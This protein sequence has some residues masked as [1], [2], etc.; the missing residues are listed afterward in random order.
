MNCKELKYILQ[1]KLLD[2]L[3]DTDRFLI[4]QHIQSCNSCNELFYDVTNTLGLIEEDKKK[5]AHPF[6][7]E[8]LLNKIQNES[9][10]IKSPRIF[11]TRK[12]LQTAA[13][14]ILFL[15]SVSAGIFLGRNYLIS[16]ENQHYTNNEQYTDVQ[17]TN[18]FEEYVRVEKYL[19]E[20]NQ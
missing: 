2:E 14:V 10:L 6:F 1:T 12:I 3:N 9:L 16:S 11:I 13:A 4:N 15:L 18:Y 7:K 17:Y 20:E 8:S 19:F 5:L